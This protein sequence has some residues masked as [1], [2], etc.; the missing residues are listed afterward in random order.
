MTC[1]PGTAV[2]GIGQNSA[3]SS[4]DAAYTTYAVVTDKTRK[5]RPMES[6]FNVSRIVPSILISPMIYSRLTTRPQMIFAFSVLQT[7]AIGMAKL[8][9]LF[10]F[11]RI[12][13][14]TTFNILSWTTIGIV[15]GWTVADFFLTDFQCQEHVSMLWN[16]TKDYANYCYDGE[17]LALTFTA[18]DVLTDFIILV[19]PIYWVGLLERSPKSED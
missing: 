3:G 14:G 11:R 8:S 12:F 15:I 1:F 10:F 9:F 6:S 2:A 19:Q 4:V 7:P 13:R 5:V 18:L 16:P 17:P